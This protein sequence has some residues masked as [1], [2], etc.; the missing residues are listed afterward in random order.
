M[1]KLVASLSGLVVAV[2]AS[3]SAHAQYPTKPVRIIVPYAAGGPSDVVTRIVAEKLSEK[4]KQPVVVD[5]KPGASGAIGVQ[6][7]M[8]SPPDG[9]VLLLHNVS[10]MTI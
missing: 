1:L 6:A 4:W 3:G 10:G 8:A 2:A 9:Y 5:N 7:L